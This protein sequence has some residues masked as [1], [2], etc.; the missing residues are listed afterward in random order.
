MDLQPS[1]VTQPVLKEGH[2]KKR[3]GRMQQWTHRYFLLTTNTLSYKLKQDAPNYRF[4]YD[5]S[6]GCIVTDIITEN[7]V[8]GK[9]LYSF[10]LVWPHE[11]KGEKKEKEEG[12]DDEHDVSQPTTSSSNAATLPP[13]TPASANKGEKDLKHIVEQEALSQRRVKDRVHEQLELHQAHDVNVSIGAKVA[14]VAVGGVIVGALTAG[15]GLVPYLTVVGIT[16]AAS[17]GAVAFSFRRPLD[18][19]LIMAAE[20]MAEAVEWKAAIEQQ[21]ALL[22][23]SLRPALPS[24]VDRRLI[25]SILDHNQGSTLWQT[26]SIF[27][28]LRIF[29]QLFGD[30]SPG[31]RCRRAQVVVR[32]PPTDAFLSLMNTRHWPQQGE[33]RAVKEMDDHV[34]YIGVELYFPVTN[35]HRRICF[36]RFWQLDDDGVYL[37]TLNSASSVDFPHAIK[38]PKQPDFQLI[39][40]EQLPSIDAVFT[41]MPRQD[42][43]HFVFDL[44]EALVSISVQV[45]DPK[46][47]WTE[48]ETEAFL[49]SFLED[50]LLEL[51][52][53]L[54]AQRFG[55]SYNQKVLSD[56]PIN[57]ATTNTINNTSNGSI[58]TSI[59][60]N[61]SSN[62]NANTSS[63]TITPFK[64]SKSMTM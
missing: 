50:N 21:I 57:F 58:N 15:I 49:N 38:L 35:L 42:A 22:T 4:T 1:P 24:T 12:S 32:A 36:S 17:G 6:P 14:A 51:R 7:R 25:S 5:L 29:H 64:K 62:A 55:Q 19:R 26:V 44:S 54:L 53:S 59:S 34:D 45:N 30:N 9:K 2:L 40:S 13:P 23:E 37:I 39:S 10:W 8:A 41:V 63:Q 43:E 48:K 46:G 31:T 56:A 60:V 61:T 3:N 20:T 33:C 11:K 47:L 28:Q 18:S 16:A 27:E 52:Y